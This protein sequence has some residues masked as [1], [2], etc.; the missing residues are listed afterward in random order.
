[1]CWTFHAVGIA[2][3]RWLRTACALCTR[4]AASAKPTLCTHRTDTSASRS[5]TADGT[6][7]TAS[8]AQRKAAS[9]SKKR[10]CPS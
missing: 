8:S 7:N 5:T 3:A 1:S 6:I 10:T 4:L 9:A 2:S